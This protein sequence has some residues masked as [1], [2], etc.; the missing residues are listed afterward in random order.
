MM[1]SDRSPILHV[2]SHPILPNPVYPCEC[3]LMPCSRSAGGMTNK[4]TQ[5]MHDAK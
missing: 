1:P 5:D 4:D 3:A 2:S